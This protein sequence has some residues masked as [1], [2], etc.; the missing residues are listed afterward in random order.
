[1][2][3]KPQHHLQQPHHARPFG[4]DDHAPDPIDE[5]AASTAVG[6]SV[7][8]SISAAVQHLRGDATRDHALKL[9]TALNAT[10]VFVDEFRPRVADLNLV[11]AGP[12]DVTGDRDQSRAGI[13]RRTHFAES[14]GPIG[15]DADE[16]RQRLDVVDDGGPLIKTANGETRRPIARITALAFDRT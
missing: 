12:R 15:D 4:D 9:L 16:V 8:G 7:R 3:I 5:P 11:D 2:V 6:S 13:L 14:V 10:A 1:V